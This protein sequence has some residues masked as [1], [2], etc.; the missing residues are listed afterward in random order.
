MSE[1]EENPKRARQTK[2]SNRF[3]SLPVEFLI[4]YNVTPN[5]ISYIGFILTSLSAILI[6]M[7]FMYSSIEFS[8]T[9]PFLFGLAGAFGIGLWRFNK[10]FLGIHSF[11][12]SYND[13]LYSLKS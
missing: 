8:W 5:K 11:V 4:K 3:I 10:L 9:I 1:V 7:G 12:S 6:A 13:F 2:T